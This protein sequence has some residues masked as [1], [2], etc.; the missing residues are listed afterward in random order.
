VYRQLL[1]ATSPPA[2]GPPR[3]ETE[4]YPF[5]LAL[6]LA[7]LLAEPLISARNLQAAAVVL[8]LVW[9]PPGRSFQLPELPRPTSSAPAQATPVVTDDTASVVN[10]MSRGNQEFAAGHYGDA[11]HFYVWA[12]GTAPNSPEVLF[13]LALAFYKTESYAEAASTFERAATHA[14]DPKFRA[15]CKF[16]QANASYRVAMQRSAHLFDFQQALALTIPLYRDAL[17]LDPGLTDCKY[18]IEVIKRKLRELT[19]PMR[20]ASNRFMVQSREDLARRQNTEATQILQENKNAKKT[21][22]QVG[23]PAIDTD[24]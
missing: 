15:K 1:A 22:G 5:L 23:R 20:A 13:D 12:V 11:V 9:T 10:W 4:G 18:N 16:G 3:N 19:G 6:A 24:W 7:L 21:K 14:R 2:A 17:A 8:F